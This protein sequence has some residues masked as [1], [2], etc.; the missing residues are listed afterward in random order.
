MSRESIVENPECSIITSLFWKKVATGEPLGSIPLN[1]VSFWV[2]VHELPVGFM[3]TTVGK[4]LGN[5]IGEFQEYDP[6]NASGHR[7]SYMQIKVIIDVRKPLKKE[8][9]VKKLGGE[10]R[11]MKFKYEKLGVF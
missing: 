3:S 6:N 8:Q 2:Q 5:Y 10:W 11:N 7:R 4:H 9:K 1:H